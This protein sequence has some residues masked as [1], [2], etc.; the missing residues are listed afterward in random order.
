M[1]DTVMGPRERQERLENLRGRLTPELKERIWA[2]VTGGTLP[3][4][5]LE[6]IS[7]PALELLSRDAAPLES[8]LPIAALEGIVQRFGRPPLLVRNDKVVLEELTDFPA[9]TP[10]KIKGVERFIPSIGRIEFVNHRMSWGGTGWVIGE[11]A[12]K[13]LVVTNRHVAQLIARRKADGSGVFLRAPSGARYG[14]KIDFREE[15]GSPQDDSR[16]APV[17]AIEYLADDLAADVAL[18][19]VEAA[20]FAMPSPLELE[21]RT[22]EKDEFVAIIGY[23]AYDSRYD[24]DDQSRY[25]R[26]LYE[27]KRFAPGRIMQNAGDDALLTHDC[28]SLGGNSGSPVVSLENGAVLGLHF[29]GR[30]GKGNGA[31]GA[32]TLQALLNGERPIFNKLPPAPEAADGHHDATRFANRKGFNTTFLKEDGTVATPWPGLPPRLEEGLAKPSDNPPDK[33]ELRYMHFGVKYSGP[34]KLPLITAVNID[35]ERA[36]RIK[37]DT[38]KWFSDGRI[39]REIQ[40]GKNNFA[41]AQIDRGHMVRREDPNWA[42][43]DAPDEAQTAN[44]DTFHYVNAA[45]QHS[46]LNQGKALWLGLEDYILESTRTHGFRA[47]V[48]TGPVLRDEDDEDEEVVIDDAIVPLEFW[49]VVA[50]LDETDSTLRATAYLLSQGQLVRK[51]LEKRSRRESLEGFALGEYRTFQLS[52]ADLEEATG[53]DFSAYRD[54]DPLNRRLEAREA[55]ASGEPVVIPIEQ[56]SDLL[57]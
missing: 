57:L 8:M 52:V 51:L 30:Y 17:A 55:R 47:C 14:V 31:V 33:H 1:V 5:L 26:D 11:K 54:A 7:T 16:T 56:V 23:P 39:P 50:T 42:P 44:D 12:G 27:V 35:G 21:V 19:R 13:S 53:Y 20:S 28:T 45:P 25:F 10:A 15:M 3:R 40:L 18:L 24:A 49:K 6:A 4:P 41:D 34:Y 37:R 22:A 9:E 36:V 38:D 48:F 2:A 32:A 46:T 29:T 43:E